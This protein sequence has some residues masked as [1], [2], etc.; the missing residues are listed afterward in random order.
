MCTTWEFPGASSLPNGMDSRMVAAA[1]SQRVARRTS[2]TVDV[3]TS[4]MDDGWI[5]RTAAT[6]ISRMFENVISIAVDAAFR[7]LSR[8]SEE[9]STEQ[10]VARTVVSDAEENET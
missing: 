8:T 10:G 3:D 5:S 1:I 6:A 9:R 7:K 4:R 2:R